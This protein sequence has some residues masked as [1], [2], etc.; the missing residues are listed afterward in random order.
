MKYGREANAPTEVRTIVNAHFR[1]DKPTSLPWD[2]PFLGLVNAET[3]WIFVRDNIVSLTISAANNLADSPNWEIANKLWSEVGAVLGPTASRLPA[4]RIIKERRATFAQIP[5]QVNARPGTATRSETFSW[6][7][8]G[9][10][11]AFRRLLKAAFVGLQCRQ[12]G[13]GGGSDRDL[14][15]G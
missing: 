14:E 2:M 1:L 6:P 4:W 11:P 7:A 13:D 9:L 15:R 12:H 10:I 8:T 5:S 3:H